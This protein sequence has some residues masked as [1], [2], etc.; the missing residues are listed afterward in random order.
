MITKIDTLVPII[1][2]LSAWISGPF[3]IFLA[4][5]FSV[6]VFAA[7]DGTAGATRISEVSQI[8]DRAQITSATDIALGAIGGSRSLTGQ[9][10]SC[11]FRSNSEN[12]KMN[13]TADAG[14]HTLLV[15]RI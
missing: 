13:L 10:D 1:V 15:S 11:L 3:I 12:Y 4:S 5:L 6:A 9:S 8:I 7:S 2:F 14:V